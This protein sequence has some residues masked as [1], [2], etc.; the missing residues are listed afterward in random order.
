MIRDDHPSGAG[1]LAVVAAVG[2]VL[3]GTAI[4]LAAVFW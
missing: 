3:W 2:V 1:A 4:V